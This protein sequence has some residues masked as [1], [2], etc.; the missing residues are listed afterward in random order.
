TRF[1]GKVA[2]PPHELIIDLGAERTIRG[3]VYLA[4]QDSGWNGAIKDIEFCISQSPDAFGEPVIKTKLA[5]QK[6]PQVVQCPATQGRYIMLRA[7]SAHSQQPFASAAE[8]GVIG[9]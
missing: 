6:E 5:R 2:T 4:R 1:A 9:E 8:I 3:F 7:H